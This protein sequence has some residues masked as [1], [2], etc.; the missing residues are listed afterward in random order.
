MV[1]NRT[2]APEVSEASPCRISQFVGENLASVL[3][4][5]LPSVGAYF[6]R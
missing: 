3:F 4:G 1:G 2:S 5:R 6:S